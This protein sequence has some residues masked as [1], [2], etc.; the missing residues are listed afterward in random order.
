[1]AQHEIQTQPS[2][3]TVGDLMAQ[4]SGHD[5]DRPVLIGADG[6]WLNIVGVE[7]DPEAPALSIESRDNFDTRQW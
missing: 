2:T 4:L 3:M 7:S 1:M 5:P 6:W